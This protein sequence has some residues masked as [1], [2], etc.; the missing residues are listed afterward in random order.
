MSLVETYLKVVAA[1]LPAAQRDDVVAELRDEIES[2]IEAREAELARR[3]TDD[4]IE[5]VL[6]ELGHPLTVAARFRPGPQHVV[7]PELYPYWRFAVRMGLLVVVI[8]TGLGVMARLMT[9]AE[10]GY[11]IGDAFGGLFSGAM[12]LIGIATVAALILERQAER[13]GFLKDWRVKDLGIYEFGLGDDFVSRVLDGTRARTDAVMGAGKAPTGM[14]A[15]TLTAQALGAVALTVVFLLWW[16]GAFRV[17]GFHPLE[18][19]L[20]RDGVDYGRIAAETFRAL[21]WPVIA[22]GAARIGFDLIR[23]GAPAARRFAAAGEVGFGLAWLTILSWV[24][25][26]S[27]L[28]PWVQVE[29]IDGLIDRF[30]EAIHWPHPVP[31]ILTVILAGATADT[32][33]RTLAQAVKAVRGR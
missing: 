32:A 4:E 23:A 19:D 11:V 2:R 26:R 25:A 14:G 7:G 29:S 22:F 28:A 33:I 3:L 13:P 1:H 27:P 20:V 21:Y 8:F 18:I 30:R 12:T 17:V 10:P 9:G 5:A 24:W 15:G 31:A 16:T 6:R